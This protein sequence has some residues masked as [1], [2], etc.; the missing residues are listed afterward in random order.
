MFV[1]LH[2]LLHP[3]G[4]RT[5]GGPQH[6]DAGARASEPG[7]HAR[8]NRDRE[9]EALRAM[10]RLDA[11]CGLVGLGQQWLVHSGHGSRLQRSPLGE[12]TK[13]AR[14]RFFERASLVDQETKSTPHVGRAWITKRQQCCSAFSQKPFEQHRWGQEPALAPQTMQMGNGNCYRMRRRNR[15]RDRG[16]NIPPATVAPPDHKIDVGAGVER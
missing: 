6:T 7:R 3:Y 5:I 10:D 14:V 13:V 11:E 2:P 1:C 8:Q 15:V 4:G 9:L 16:S 12:G